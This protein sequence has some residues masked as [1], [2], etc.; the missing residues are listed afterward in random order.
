MSVD[1]N[2]NLLWP[3]PRPHATTWAWPPPPPCGRHKWMAPNRACDLKHIH[4][5]QILRY[6]SHVYAYSRCEA[7]HCSFGIKVLFGIKITFSILLIQNFPCWMVIHQTNVLIH[8]FHP[9]NCK[10]DDCY[11]NRRLSINVQTKAA[12]LVYGNS[13]E[14]VAE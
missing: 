12:K 3:L 8:V 5:S 2:L 1:S 7:Q 10:F 14:N 4:C 13:E 6:Q 9:L 11:T